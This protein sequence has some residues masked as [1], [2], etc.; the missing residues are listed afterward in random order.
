MS[1]ISGRLVI[2]TGM[3]G[4][5]K[6]T[7]LRTFEDLGYYCLDNLPP[8]L[9]EPF[10]QLYR[11]A[12]PHA[13]GVAVVCDVRSGAMFVNFR[14]AIQALVDRGYSP[15]IIF[16]DCD[17]DTLI[18]RYTEARRGHPIGLGLRIEEAVR[19]ERQQIDQLKELASQVVDT[20]DL[21]VQQLRQRILGLYTTG[22]LVGRLTVTIL[23]FGFKFGVPSDADF[24][25]D[26]RF[27]PNPFY[28]E[29]LRELTGNNADVANFV[30]SS[31][32]AMEFIERASDLLLLALPRYTEVQ[33]LYAMVAIGC[34]GGKHRSVAVANELAKH[35]TNNNLRCVVQHRDIDRI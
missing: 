33:K 19:L 9:I 24:L 17:D 32:G 2:L 13:G 35:I 14:D 8:T 11:Q 6:S 30:L 25:F 18:A 15:E 21:A 5:G 20:S 4:A 16:F 31:P 27:L 34:T 12:I 23:S 29:P 28:I 22:E 7:A 26:T 3:S 10:I 1:A